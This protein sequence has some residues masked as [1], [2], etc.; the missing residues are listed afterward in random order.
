[1][2][3]GKWWGTDGGVLWHV[4]EIEERQKG[5]VRYNTFSCTVENPNQSRFIYKAYANALGAQVP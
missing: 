2:G 4:S 1:M 5:A 3:V